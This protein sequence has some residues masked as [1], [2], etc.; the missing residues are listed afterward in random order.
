MGGQS[1]IRLE[2]AAAEPAQGTRGTLDM[3]VA[4]MRE[5]P[6]TSSLLTYAP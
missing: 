4:P 1:W 5:T 6:T 3:G 2:G